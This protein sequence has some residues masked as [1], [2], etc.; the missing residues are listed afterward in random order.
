VKNLPSS[1]AGTFLSFYK[2]KD[3]LGDSEDHK[4]APKFEGPYVIVDRAPHNVYKL[5]HFH[6]GKILNSHVHVDKLKPCSSARA[7]RRKRRQIAAIDR[8][9]DAA[10]ESRRPPNGDRRKQGRAD[11]THTRTV[12][13][14]NTVRKYGQSR[15]TA[16][17]RTKKHLRCD[18]GRGGKPGGGGTLAPANG[19]STGA[20][21]C[22]TAGAAGGAG[23][24]FPGGG[25]GPL[26]PTR[27]RRPGRSA[28]TARSPA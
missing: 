13:Y 27:C 8:V 15:I 6:T 25:G 18:A 24:G 3:V 21:A 4:T 16:E 11:A 22:T 12:I 1:N 14:R 19:G 7:A 10:T 20:G 28:D 17:I 5:Q 23:A 9:R 2:V 26:V